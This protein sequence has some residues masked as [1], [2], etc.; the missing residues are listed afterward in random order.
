MFAKLKKKVIEENGG[1]AKEVGDRPLLGSP[2]AASLPGNV[3]P[4]RRNSGTPTPVHSPLSKEPPSKGADAQSTP[5]LSSGDEASVRDASVSREDL[6]AMLLKRTEQCKKMEGNISDLA[7][8]IK[9][10]N[11][12]IEQLETQIKQHE[13][14]LAQRLGE[15]KSE[16]EAYRDKLIAGY[17]EDKQALGKEKQELMQKLH[18]AE[19]YRDKFLKREADTDEIQDFATQELAKVKHMLLMTQGELETCKKDLTSKTELLETA[20]AKVKQLETE[21]SKTTEKSSTLEKEC[22]RLREDN[23]ERAELVMALTKEKSVFERRLEQLNSELTQKQKQVA[24]L[25]EQLSDLDGKLRSVEH[26]TEQHKNKYSVV[27]VCK[28]SAT[29][30]MKTLEVLAAQQTAKL[31]EEK[32]DHIDVLEERVAT[33]QQRLH[34]HSLSGDERVTALQA[35]RDTVEKKLSEMRQQLTEVKSTWS[36]KISHLEEQISHL[37]TKIVEDSEEMASNQRAADSMRENFHRQIEELRSKVEDAERR[38]L[39]NYELACSK[40]THYEQQVRDLETALSHARLTTVDTETQLRSK[41]NSL[42]MQLSEL[43]TA[44][45]A[46]QEEA[47]NKLE[48]LQQQNAQSVEREL[49]MEQTLKAAEARCAQLQV[50]A[51]NQTEEVTRLRKELDSHSQTSQG[52]GQKVTELEQKIAK[53]QTELSSAT[54]LL[55]TTQKKFAESDKERGELMVR[56][57]QLSQQVTS[58]NKKLTQQQAEMDTLMADRDGTIQSQEM[59]SAQTQ[60]GNAE[61][62][63]STIRDLQDQLADKTRTLKKQEQTVKD[64][65]QTLQRELKV[66]ALPN[67]DASDDASS[68]ATS[69]KFP[70]RQPATI[71]VTQQSHN[72]NSLAPPSTSYAAASSSSTTAAV[73]PMTVGSTMAVSDQRGFTVRRDLEQDVNFQYLKHVVLKFMLSRESEAVQLIKAVAVLLNFTQQEQQLIKQT[74]EWKMSWFGSR[75]SAGKGQMAKVV[76]PSF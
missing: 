16:F 62:F 68:P 8:L 12:T 67:D 9:D 4:L 24:E 52:H 31:L 48:H 10:K 43:Q 53:L 65:R 11:R 37:N 41:L 59:Q 45:Q 15:Q 30:D 33:L 44:R 23:K 20:Q 28:V 66:Q 26:S 17:Q 35:E 34:D 58:H 49:H 70:P 36:D 61:H 47:K 5:S 14:A 22:E 29:A 73:K 72:N 32:Q 1:K 2:G 3:S 75:P 71:A 38:A 42:E 64:L 69:R 19:E 46:E 21:L 55:S 6:A 40:D 56:N 57:A 25:N 60:M 27:T 76:P 63:E 51:S 50:E 39:E 18:E 54:A 13:E 74:L 7:S